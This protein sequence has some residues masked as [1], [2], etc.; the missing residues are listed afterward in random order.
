GEPAKAMD[1]FNEGLELARRIGD[2]G[3]EALIQGHIARIERDRGDLLAAK[4]RIDQVLAAVGSLRIRVKSHQLLASFFGY[5]RKYYELDSDRLMGLHKQQP[6]AGY[7][8]AAFE[9]SEKG[10]ARSLLE[11]LAETVGDQAGIDPALAERERVLRL[12][13]SGKADGQIR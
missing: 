10:R 5:V 4:S 9:M 3:R 7:E 1:Y 12:M 11:L 2:R 8:A 6:A 13:I